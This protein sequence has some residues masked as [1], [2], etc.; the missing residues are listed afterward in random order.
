MITSIIAARVVDLPE[1]VGP[2]TR[3]KPRGLRGQLAQHLRH[4]ERVEGR[5]L[6][7]DEAEGGAD[8]AALEEAVDA[9]AGD[10]GDRVG[11]V[12][13]LV[14]LEAFALV[15]VED[16]VDD[17]AGLLAGRATGKPSI[18]TILPLS[19]IAGG[20]PGGEVDV[21]GPRLDH[22]AQDL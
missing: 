1:P 20:K 9:E 8:R 4:A 11:E 2:V 21:G 6:L 7:R 18:G 22:A 3:T 14:V 15:V 16:A 12:E 5:D 10:A 19:R 17:L 13:L